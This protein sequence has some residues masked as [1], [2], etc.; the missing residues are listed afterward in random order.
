MF[1]CTFSDQVTIPLKRVKIF[2]QPFVHI[3]LHTLLIKDNITMQTIPPVKIAREMKT[4]QIYSKC[5]K[6]AC[7]VT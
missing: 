6:I 4:P 2:I 1:R 7:S 3:V 5:K